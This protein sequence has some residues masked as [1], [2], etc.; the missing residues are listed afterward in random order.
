MPTVL[1]AFLAHGDE[2]FGVLATDTGFELVGRDLLGQ[3]LEDLLLVSQER[4]NQYNTA[5]WGMIA[6]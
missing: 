6:A 3:V 5:G 1:D 2:A 4:K